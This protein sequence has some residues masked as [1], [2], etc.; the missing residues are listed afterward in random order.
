MESQFLRLA[1][2]PTDGQEFRFSDKD[3][4]LQLLQSQESEYLFLPADVRLSVFPQEDGLLFQ[5]RLCGTLEAPCDRCLETA[6][7]EI[8]FDIEFFSGFELEDRDMFLLDTQ[9]GMEIDIFLL[10]WEQLVLAMP[11]KFL[12]A[13]DCKGLCPHCGENKN[14][15]DCDCVLGSSKKNPFAVLQSL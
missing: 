10:L 7:I 11:E 12:C 1:N 6:Q 13:A 4:W 8:D 14:K 15:T 9:A 2:I 3:F 5:G